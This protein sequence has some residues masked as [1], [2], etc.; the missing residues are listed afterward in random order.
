MN[1]K[2]NGAV[3]TRDFFFL[4]SKEERKMKADEMIL[5]G[6]FA[7]FSTADLFPNHPSV[8]SILSVCQSL[9][10]VHYYGNQLVET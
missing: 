8:L 5:T 6:G 10:S 4:V 2:L 3:D 7:C 9:V 1:A